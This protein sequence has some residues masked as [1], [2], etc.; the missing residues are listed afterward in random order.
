MNED[1]NEIKNE[2]VNETTDA[3]VTS[4]NGSQLSTQTTLNSQSP[5]SPSLTV[6]PPPSTVPQFIK[7]PD[8]YSRQGELLTPEHP[9]Y[10]AILAIITRELSERFQNGETT[11]AHYFASPANPTQSAASASLSSAA[12]TFSGW[13]P[14]KGF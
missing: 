11:L 7:T 2:I 3:N 12:E 4:A 1:I 8:V 9:D 10:P 13:E 6:S 14:E 5:P